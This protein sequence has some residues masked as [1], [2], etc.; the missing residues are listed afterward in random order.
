MTDR[1]NPNHKG[2]MCK[3]EMNGI[4]LD[5]VMDEAGNAY[6]HSNMNF[7]DDS[8][9]MFDGSDKNIIP[10]HQYKFVR[11]WTGFDW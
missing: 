6:H 1:N 7:D 10:K 11:G 3:I 8:T 9:Y 5:C 4:Q 2:K